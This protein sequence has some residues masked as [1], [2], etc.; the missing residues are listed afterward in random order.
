MTELIPEFEFYEFGRPYEKAIDEKAP[1]QQCRESSS[2]NHRATWRRW[3]PHWPADVEMRGE[4]P[5]E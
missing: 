4:P 1:M 3:A 2:G 5:L